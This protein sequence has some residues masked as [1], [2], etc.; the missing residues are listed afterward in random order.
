MV[1]RLL[2]IVISIIHDT[3]T[4]AGVGDRILCLSGLLI[5]PACNIHLNMAVRRI[6]E[7]L[8]QNRYGVNIRKDLFSILETNDEVAN[9]Q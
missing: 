5:T 1:L 6:T 2:F 8:S 9:I 7:T 3:D 4:A